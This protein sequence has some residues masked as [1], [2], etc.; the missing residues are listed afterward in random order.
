MCIRDR[1]KDA[2]IDLNRKVLADLAMNEPAAFKE[3]VNTANNAPKGGAKKPAAAKTEA[4]K[5]KAAPAKP[6]AEAPKA[7]KPAAEPKK[8]TAPK[9][10]A[11]AKSEGDDLK[12]INKI[13]PAFEKRLNALGVYSYA[14]L[15][16]LTDAKIE[17][18]EE[19][20]SMTSYE[21]WQE[22]IKEAKTLA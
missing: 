9:K 3:I 19:K 22:W 21:Q 4:P 7:E 12:V 11:A 6:K 5:E 14:D 10:K 16:G 13:G 8:E 2:N 1:L 17:E 15:A 20:D 18:Y